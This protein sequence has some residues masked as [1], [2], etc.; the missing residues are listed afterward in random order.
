MKGQNARTYRRHVRAHEAVIDNEAWYGD[1][2]P[3][4]GKAFTAA[5]TA[6]RH[7]LLISILLRAADKATKAE[8]LPLHAV[9]NFC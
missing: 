5:M 9:T 6:K 3:D 2:L 7:T 8:A 4:L 1:G